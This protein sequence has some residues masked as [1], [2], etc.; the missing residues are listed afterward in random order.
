M[1]L[2]ASRITLLA[3]TSTTATPTVIPRGMIAIRKEGGTY[4]DYN[5]SKFGFSSVNFDGSGDYLKT[6]YK[7]DNLGTGAFTWECF[8]QVDADAGD[9]TVAVLSN[10]HGSGVSG[11][12]QMLFRNYDMKVQVNAYGGTAAFD[13]NGVGSALATD[14][15]HH[16]AFARDDS[17]NVAVFVN[18]TRVSN[19][20][21]DG[22]VLSDSTDVP[23]AIGAQ[24]SGQISMNSGDEGWVDEARISKVD[25]YGVSNTSYT[26][27]TTAFTND[28]N[29]TFL[30][31]AEGQ[32]SNSGL[33]EDDNGIRED[34][35]IKVGG[36]ADISEQQQAIGGT[37]IA[38][39]GNGD[40]LR[41]KRNSDLYLDSSTWTIEFNIR[42]D[43]TGSQVVT[44]DMDDSSLSWLMMTN[45]GHL[46]WW[47][48]S[49]GSSWDLASAYTIKS[50]ISTGVWY[51]IALVKDSS[52]V[53]RA[54]VDGTENTG[55]YYTQSSA[56]YNT[57]NDVCVGGLYEGSTAYVSGFM[58]DYRIS[59][60]AR[61]TSNFT[62]STVKLVND[63]NTVVL[64]HPDG[65]NNS[66]YIRDDNGKGRAPVSVDQCFGGTLDDTQSKYRFSSYNL[67][68]D[69]H[70]I[71]VRDFKSYQGVKDIGSSS[72]FTIEGWVYKNGT[73]HNG[74]SVTLLEVASGSNI[75]AIVYDEDNS[76]VKYLTDNTTRIS[77]GDLTNYNWVH[78]AV[79]RDSSNNTKL[80]LNG[81][82]SGSTYSSDNK[83]WGSNAT[84]C[85]IGCDRNGG[86]SFKGH[87]SDW[88]ISKSQRTYSGAA[89]SDTLANDANTVMLLH[90]DSSQDGPNDQFFDDNGDY[91]D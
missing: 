75:C 87:M 49:N 65:Q 37:S 85:L 6:K 71:K 45:S 47:A 61:Y 78:V 70:G 43:S 81:S 86:N 23:F 29:T 53:V 27:P 17:N 90:F 56:F 26:V 18:G 84:Q 30:F 31:H 48:S 3:R 13:A 57:G 72:E 66:Q 22:T 74:S 2:G 62:P 16:F 73:Q 21:W 68:S 42:F 39:D 55:F 5:R 88:R 9:G 44:A 14:T 33:M 34:I 50:N 83:D 51:H 15:W 28:S 8:F 32:T 79:V 60:I 58:S 54:Y 36:N 38:L 52:N 1:P 35:P 69:G 91:L 12:I 4:L 89:P 41:L 82:Q 7:T 11:N 63:A 19:G 20:T 25:R 76:Q 59:R 77:G 46:R 67:T 64:I 24:C 10:R 40:F 80:Y